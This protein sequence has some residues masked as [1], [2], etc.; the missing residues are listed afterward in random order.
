MQQ[1]SNPEAK[2]NIQTYEKPPLP[3]KPKASDETIFGLV[4]K[5]L[6]DPFDVIKK[7]PSSHQLKS[8]E[9]S[10]SALANAGRNI[11]SQ[12]QDQRKPKN[13]VKDNLNRVVFE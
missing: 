5:K 3:T 11:L 12:K 8:R 9:K 7:Q 2:E 6:E 10:E 4:Q 13:F 1:A